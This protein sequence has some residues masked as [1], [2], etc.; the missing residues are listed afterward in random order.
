MGKRDF[1]HGSIKFPNEWHRDA[2]RG[3]GP[4]ATRSVLKEF[5]SIGHYNGNHSIFSVH[6]DVFGFST[7]S[8][9]NRHTS[10]QGSILT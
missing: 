3:V 2:S 9:A 8:Q 4:I 6:S 7:V 5:S 10:V 1:G